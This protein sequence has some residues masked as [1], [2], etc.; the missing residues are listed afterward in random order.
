MTST[1]C[2]KLLT[3]SKHIVAEQT[4]STHKNS[5]DMNPAHWCCVSEPASSLRDLE[6]QCGIISKCLASRWAGMLAFDPEICH[7][8]SSEKSQGIK[9]QITNPLF[10]YKRCIELKASLTWVQY[11]IQILRSS[12]VTRGSDKQSTIRPRNRP[13]LETVEWR[14]AQNIIFFHNDLSSQK[15]HRNMSFT[16]QVP[17]IDISLQVAWN[18]SPSQWHTA[19]ISKVRRKYNVHTHQLPRI[20]K[21]Y[22]SISTRL[23]IRNMT[24]HP[25][26]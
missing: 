1:T 26:P 19:L 23:N 16:C 22:S 8:A 11:E 12:W 21:L 20:Q 5:W 2:L 13:C 15:Q 25:N 6:Y 18:C 4:T 10:I 7:T 24:P 3:L 9:H 17:K 14:Q